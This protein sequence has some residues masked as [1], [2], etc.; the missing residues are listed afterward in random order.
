MQTLSIIII[1]WNDCENLRRCLT[2][3]YKSSH[4]NIHEIIVI[5]NGSLDKTATMMSANFPEVKL[6]INEH[7]KGITKARNQGVDASTGHFLLFL[8]SD[9]EV[10][11]LE[12]NLLSFMQNNDRIGILGC[13]LLNSDGT[14]QY[15]CRTFPTFSVLFNRMIGRES[16]NT[17]K[18]YLMESWDHESFQ[19]VDWVMGACLLI[20]RETYKGINGFDE[21]YFYGYDDVDFC[22][23]ALCANWMCF[24]VPSSTL[25]HHYQ[26]KSIKGGIKSKFWW[27]H[28]MSALRFLFKRLNF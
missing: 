9:I 5:D 16:S 14:L 11:N 10:I 15:S 6:I 23:R 2:S 20:R 4:Q 19:K 21:K 18:K 26:R 1:S 24:Y 25:K 13:K 27:Y 28:L 3:L 22:Y 12:K 17:V 8:D 7:N